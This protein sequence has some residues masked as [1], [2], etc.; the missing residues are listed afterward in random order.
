MLQKIGLLTLFITLSMAES[1]WTH[2]RDILS[3]SDNG[4][5][6]PSNRPFHCANYFVHKFRSL[7]NELY[8]KPHLTGF[9]EI[10]DFFDRIEFQNRGTAHTHSCYWM[11]NTIETMIAHDVIRSTMPDPLLEPELYAVVIA[12]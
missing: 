7:K 5:T 12:N 4:D 1:R 9:G 2:L 3:V 11:T 10:T 8:K 6:L